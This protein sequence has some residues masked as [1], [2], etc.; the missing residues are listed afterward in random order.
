MPYITG[1]AAFGNIQA[2]IPG[3]PGA[4]TTNAGW[5]IGGGVEVALVGN[6][7]A[8]AEYLYVDLGRFDCGTNCGAIP[9]DNVNF[10]ANIVRG[11]LNY[12]F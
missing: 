8:K 12:R 5:T 7:T 1:G 2:N 10:R 11:G 6:W 9:P 3:L 4:S